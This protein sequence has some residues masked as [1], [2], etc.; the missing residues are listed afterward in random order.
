MKGELIDVIA[1]PGGGAVAVMVIGKDAVLFS[2]LGSGM[3]A[4]R[5]LKAC[6]DALS[7]KLAVAA[8]EI[9]TVAIAFGASDPR[10]QV[11]VVP[12]AVQAPNVVVAAP[13]CDAP[14]KVSVS[15][16]LGAAKGPL[17]MTEMV[18]LLAPPLTAVVGPVMET[19]M[20]AAAAEGITALDGNDV[21][22]A[23][24]TFDAVTVN[25]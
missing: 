15:V 6:T 1:G 21:G 22:P 24:I 4:D 3:G 8:S 5:A 10:L 2:V 12:T 9:V 16:T 25:V 23:P 14:T 18:S 7:V 13:T 19:A 20:S 17:L 11:K